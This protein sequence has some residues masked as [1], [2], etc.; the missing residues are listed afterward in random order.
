MVLINLDTLQRVDESELRYRLY[1]EVSFAV[2]LSDAALE[3][4]PFKVLNEPEKPVI[5]STQNVVDNGEEEIDGKWYVTW[6][7]VEKTPQ[8]LYAE[9][10][11]VWEIQ[12]RLASID[13]ESVRPL[14]EVAAG[15]GDQGATARLVELDAEFEALTAELAAL[16]V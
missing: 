12:S 5:T 2:T 13:T 6:G 16:A 15:R 14:R 7:I 3:G 4:F 9:N 1:P 10:N 8:E 11:R